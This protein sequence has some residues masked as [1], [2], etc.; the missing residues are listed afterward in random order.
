MLDASV[1]A[2]RTEWVRLWESSPM[3]LP[4]VHP[5]FTEPM[6]EPGDRLVAAVYGGGSVSARTRTASTGPGPASTPD[7]STPEGYVLHALIV[8]LLPSSGTDVISPYG[9]A[10]PLVWDA[11]DPHALARCFW[12]E[13]EAWAASIDAVSEFVRF[14]L[15]D[16]ILPFHGT[17]SPRLMNYVAELT[18]SREELWSSFAP[19]VRQNARRAIRSGVTVEFDTTGERL[20]E[21]LR[22]YHSTMIRHDSDDWY[23]FGPRCFEQLHREL[24]GGFVYAYAMHEGRAVSVDLVLLG[25]LAAYYYL[26][27]TDAG[28]FRLRPNDLVKTAALEYARSTGRTRYVLGGG[29]ETGDGLERYKRGFAPGGARM[30]CSGECVLDEDVYA[31]LTGE[32]LRPGGIQE[33][34]GCPDDVEGPGFFPAYRRRLAVPTASPR[35]ESSR[36]EERVR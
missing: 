10:G 32:A 16:D 4:F 34:G 36:P 2:E 28:A 33:S 3:R 24:P 17:T 13:F 9:Y 5:A 6:L 7:G 20:D 29:L 30:F 31:A 12:R 1:P 14:S 21:F 18:C 35:G 23:R 25:T 8:R 15:I 11:G 27:G 22:I 19:K 26:G